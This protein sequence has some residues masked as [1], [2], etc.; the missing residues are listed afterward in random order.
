MDGFGWD[1]EVPGNGRPATKCINDDAGL[2]RGKGLFLSL[3]FSVDGSD[4]GGV[5]W[6][7]MLICFLTRVFV[8]T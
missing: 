4:C 8:I 7:T 5:F 6:G 2:P 3:S 1:V